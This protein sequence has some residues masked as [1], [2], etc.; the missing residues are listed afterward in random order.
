MRHFTTTPGLI[1]SWQRKCSVSRGQRFIWLPTGQRLCRV[2]VRGGGSGDG[3]RPWGR[4]RHRGPHRSY[5]ELLEYE[6]LG[7]QDLALA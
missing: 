6:W 7:G 5:A 2:F 1:F 4:R 3:V